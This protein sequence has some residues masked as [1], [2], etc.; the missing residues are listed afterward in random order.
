MAFKISTAGAGN[1]PSPSG[2]MFIRKFALYVV[3]FAKLFARISELLFALILVE[4]TTTFLL[5]K[6]FLS[7]IF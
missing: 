3:P 1:L 7:R 6:L 4:I 2:P 5:I